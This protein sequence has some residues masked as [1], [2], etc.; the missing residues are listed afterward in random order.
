MIKFTLPIYWVKKY[1]T[2]PNK[3]ILVSMNFYRNAYYF[4][5]NQFKRDFSVIVAEQLKDCSEAKIEQF[6]MKYKLWYKNPNSDPSN[7]IA[8]IEKVSLDVLQELG[9]IPNDNMKYHLG[10]TWSVEG[11]DKE[12]PRCEIKLKE[13]K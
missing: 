10:S 8:L 3:T 2:K 7:I 11:I 13:I 12:K 9:Y 6:I 4:D 5:Q 1:K